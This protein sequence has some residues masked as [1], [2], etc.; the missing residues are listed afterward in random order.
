M[1]QKM[2][3]PSLHASLRKVTPRCSSITN[4]VPFSLCL[5]KVLQLE[6]PGVPK[7]GA[8][9]TGRC[10]KMDARLLPDV[11][12]ILLKDIQSLV[13]FLL[14]LVDRSPFH[15]QSVNFRATRSTPSPTLASNSQQDLALQLLRLTSMGM[16]DAG[17]NISID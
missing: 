5:E 7:S 3:P 12:L 15:V 11:A 2:P 16:P 1:P 13:P 6:H 10:L 17:P 8:I 9:S 14:Y 4:N